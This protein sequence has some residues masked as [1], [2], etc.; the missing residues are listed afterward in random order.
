MNRHSGNID[1]SPESKRLRELYPNLKIEFAALFQERDFMLSY[2][3]GFLT[4][5]YLKHIGQKQYQLFCLKTETAQLRRKQQLIQTDLNRGEKP[6]LRTIEKTIGK[7]FALYFKEIKQQMENLEKA[8]NLLLSPCLS[9][10]E[11]EEIKKL[12][13]MLVRRLHPDL[14]PNLSQQESD[15]FNQVQVAYKLCNLDKL[16][17]FTLLI[18][19]S[20]E[21]KASETKDS[22]RMT[23]ELLENQIAD[24]KDKIEKLN[25]EFPFSFKELLADESWIKEQ[26][27]RLNKEIEECEKEK[28]HLLNIIDLQLS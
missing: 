1:L 3:E 23:V 14:N 25:K 8:K 13:R 26:Q 10:E 21:D 28:S 22:L 12:Y 15:L 18:S 16:R 2:E 11:A 20:L 19:S 9:K 4:A 5:L 24:I 6:D 27:T 7:E 17:E